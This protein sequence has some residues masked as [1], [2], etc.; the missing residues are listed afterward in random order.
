MMRLSRLA[1]Q[2]I[3]RWQLRNL[4]EQTKCI[5]EARRHALARLM[6]IQRESVLKKQAL[7][8]SHASELTAGAG[9]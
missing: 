8:Q 7:W 1:R 5:L 4:E 6:E 2:W 9:H 3:I